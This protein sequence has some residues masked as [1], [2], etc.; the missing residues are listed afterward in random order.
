MTRSPRR[1]RTERAVGVIS[2]WATGASW[3]YVDPGLDSL[4]DHPRFQAIIAEIEADMAQQLG[5]VREM[6][7]LGEVP[8]LEE[9]K[10]LTASL[11]ESG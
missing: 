2:F 3:I 1:A 6:Q 9:V 4:R 8:A 7:R 10:T 5:N 11:Q